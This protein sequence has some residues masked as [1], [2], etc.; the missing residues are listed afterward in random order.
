MSKA[1]LPVKKW[2]A[3]LAA[4]IDVRLL[5]C[6]WLQWFVGCNRE[7]TRSLTHLGVGLKTCFCKEWESSFVKRLHSKAPKWSAMLHGQHIEE[8]IYMFI[9]LSTFMLWPLTRQSICK[10]TVKYLVQHI[11]YLHHATSVDKTE[12]N[13]Y[14]KNW[15]Q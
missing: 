3:P 13:I 6:V 2:T 10:I 9:L 15:A 12:I 8:N 1:I 11:R 4:T 14:I 5:T 7:L